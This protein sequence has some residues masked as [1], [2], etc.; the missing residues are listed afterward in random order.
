MLNIKVGDRVSFEV[1]DFMKV[2][3]LQRE[4]LIES[5]D[6]AVVEKISG[7]EGH[8]TL[9]LVT[10][11]GWSLDV[12]E[13]HI[14]RVYPPRPAPEA[15]PAP[16]YTAHQ[17]SVVEAAS[18]LAA[19]ASGSLE[20]HDDAQM[21]ALADW[22]R[23]RIADGWED[24]SF[25]SVKAY[26][27]CV[28]MMAKEALTLHVNSR[29]F[30]RTSLEVTASFRIPAGYWAKVDL[31]QEVERLAVNLVRLGSAL[32]PVRVTVVDARSRDR[33]DYEV[34]IGNEQGSTKTTLVGGALST[35]SDER[36]DVGDPPK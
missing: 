15:T 27:Q 22:L 16:K 5:G 28:R 34:D 2:G 14:K 31:K 29:L 32:A 35:A 21:D 19:A 24:S 33:W 25:E 18:T 26:D 17:H 20:G 10:D 11:D 8:R 30:Q 4:V 23:W 13:G 3:F 1:A 7:P 9:T 6:D 36:S 12:P